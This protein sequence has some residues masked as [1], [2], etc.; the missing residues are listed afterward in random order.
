[1]EG[2]KITKWGEDLFFFFF[3]SFST[4]QNHWNFF[5]LPKWKFSIRK[6]DFAPS[7]KYSSYAPEITTNDK[8]INLNEL[9]PCKEFVAYIDGSEQSS[10]GLDWSPVSGVHLMTSS[11]G[12]LNFQFM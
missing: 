1:M 7:E 3:F 4:F 9:G 11:S 5:G 2:G 12:A 8:V 6:N 10:H